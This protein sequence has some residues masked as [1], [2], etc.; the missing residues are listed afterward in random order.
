MK[1][2]LIAKLDA[3]AVE[4]RSFMDSVKNGTGAFDEA[5]ANAKLEEFNARKAELEKQ[6]AELEKPE[7][8]RGAEK[9]V[10]REIAEGMIEKRTVNLSGTGVVNAIRELEKIIVSKTD[11]LDGVRFFYG[12][13]ASTKVPVWGT[14]LKADFVGEG[15]TATAKTNQLG[16]TS[17][18]VQQIISSLPVSNMT[19]EL[20]AAALEA[21]LPELFAEAIADLLADGMLNGKSITVGSETV[22][23]MVGLFKTSNATAFVAGATCAKLGEL[24]RTVKS[25]K[26]KNPVIMMSNA[27]YTKFITDTTDDE[28]TK[29]YKEGLIRDKMIEDVPVELTDYAPSTG[30][31]A[32]GAWADND[33]I[34]VAGDKRGYAIA[35]AGQLKVTQKETAGATYS[36]FDGTAYAAGKPVI[37]ANFYQFKIDV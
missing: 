11:I 29:I 20:G 22:V 24:A 6:L 4:K 3:L 35:M 37:A 26:F 14:Q 2:E 30:S 5:A 19:L 34:A 21:E 25:K 10:W 27:V 13:D 33:V 7:Q 18:D 9:S 23:C 12:K 28:T 1:E 16:V 15:T 8:T 31:G 36:T 17:I 32:S